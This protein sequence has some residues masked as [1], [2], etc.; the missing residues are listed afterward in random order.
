MYNFVFHFFIPFQQN[1]YTQY[2][3]WDLQTSGGKYF[4][5]KWESGTNL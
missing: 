4:G 2:G 3:I 5:K 1:T